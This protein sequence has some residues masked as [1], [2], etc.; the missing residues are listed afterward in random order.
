MFN[1]FLLLFGGL[2]PIFRNRR[3]LVLRTSPSGNN[4]LLKRR[5]RG[6]SIGLLDKLFWVAAPLVGSGRAGQYWRLEKLKSFDELLEKRFPESRR[7]AYYPIAMHENLAKI[8]K[9][10]RYIRFA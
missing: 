10:Q 1:M 3:S 9:E 8:A 5:H 2:I 4:S 7:K 6:P